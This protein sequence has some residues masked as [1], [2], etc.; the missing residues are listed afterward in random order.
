MWD[1][2]AD[3]QDDDGS[4]DSWEGICEGWSSAAIRVPRPT[5]AITVPDPSGR[6][7]QFYPADVKA[8]SSLLSTRTK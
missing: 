6:S 5:H 3:M 1:A 4:L 8:L 2:A 7:I